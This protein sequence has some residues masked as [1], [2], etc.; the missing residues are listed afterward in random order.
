MKGLRLTE[1]KSQVCTMTGL[2]L[3]LIRYQL[4]SHDLMPIQSTR[5][6]LWLSGE[7]IY[8]L[9]TRV[10]ATEYFNVLAPE[11]DDLEVEINC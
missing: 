10:E 8:N 6:P 9:R 5:R 7:L 1:I 4:W 2:E 3:S 11:Y